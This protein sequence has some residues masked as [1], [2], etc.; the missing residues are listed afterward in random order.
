MR[1]LAVETKINSNIEVI[2]IMK[3]PDV[4]NIKIDE[5]DEGIITEDSSN[6]FQVI[7]V[8]TF[9]SISPCIFTETIK[10]S[11]VKTII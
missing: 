10:P 3:L 7:C 4:L 8:A 6:S 11:F 2:D 9:H 5:N 1:K